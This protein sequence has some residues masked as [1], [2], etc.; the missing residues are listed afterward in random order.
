MTHSPHRSD[1]DEERGHWDGEPV[2]DHE[3]RGRRRVEERPLRISLEVDV[4]GRD[5]RH[6]QVIHV[7]VAVVALLHLAPQHQKDAGSEQD[8]DDAHRSGDVA[9]DRYRLGRSGGLGHRIAP[10]V[11]RSDAASHSP[12]ATVRCCS[13]RPTCTASS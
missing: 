6:R 4:V 10:F 12:G 5:V 11:H 1:E 13:P 9:A 2:G 3:Q 8:A 7:Q